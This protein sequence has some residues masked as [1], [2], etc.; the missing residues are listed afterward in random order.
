MNATWLAKAEENLVVDEVSQEAGAIQSLEDSFT[1]LAVHPKGAIQIKLCCVVLFNTDNCNRDKSA[2][3]AKV[4]W[5]SA[6]NTP[7]EIMMSNSPRSSFVCRFALNKHSL[8][9][10]HKTRF[11]SRRAHSP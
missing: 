9:L 2:V 1:G 11:W 3:T 5:H 10:P 8:P 6:M 4:A 7:V